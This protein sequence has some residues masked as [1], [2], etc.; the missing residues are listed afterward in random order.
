MNKRGFIA[1][2]AI[3]LIG[4]TLGGFVMAEDKKPSMDDMMAAY[5]KYM[6]PGPQHKLLDPMVG[7]WDCASR[8]WMDPDSLPFESKAVSEKQWVLGGRFIQ[9]DASGDM[10]GTSFHGFGFTGYDLINQEYIRVWFDEMSTSIMFSKGQ[11]DPTGKIFTYYSEYKDP[12]DNMKEKT[13]KSVVTIVD[14]NKHMFEAYEKGPD[15]KDRK[16]FDITYTRKK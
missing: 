2:I 4:A 3:L 16:S 1:I 11:V 6:N 10:M 8:M 9:E 14:N 7:S 15:G 5:A 12:M 13:S